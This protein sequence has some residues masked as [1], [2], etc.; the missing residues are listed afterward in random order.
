MTLRFG[1]EFRK[2]LFLPQENPRPYGGKLISPKDETLIFPSLSTCNRL[3]VAKP[4]CEITGLIF[5]L[6]CS[7]I[8][9]RAL[10]YSSGSRFNSIS[11]FHW[12]NVASN[13]LDS[14]E[15]T[16]EI[17]QITEVS[18]EGMV[19]DCNLSHIKFDLLHQMTAR[20]RR[21]ISVDRKTFLFSQLIL[22][23]NR[24]WSLL[25]WCLI[26]TCDGYKV[27]FRSSI[28]TSEDRQMSDAVTKFAYAT[29]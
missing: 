19:W 28:M 12:T 26:Y 9:F 11:R 21:I 8:E 17:G 1:S 15:I 22:G 29:I 4:R 3:L 6:F 10:P 14:V 2:W 27:R 5:C 7:S 24:L 25:G 23:L 13:R 20:S 18:V 16:S